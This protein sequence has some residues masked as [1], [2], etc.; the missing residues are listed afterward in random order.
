ME[1]LKYLLVLFVLFWAS[2]LFGQSVSTNEACKSQFDSLSKRE[3]YFEVDSMPEFPGGS[4]VMMKFISDNIRWPGIELDCEGTVF[5]SFLVEIDG[6]LTNKRFKREICE[7]LD[8]EAMR[9]VDLMPRWH[10]G[11][12]NG[13]TVPVRYIFPIKFVLN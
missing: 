9:V 6:S 7:P 5:I 2:L 4:A 10:P 11:K 13:K 12:C 1:R 8:K 3:I